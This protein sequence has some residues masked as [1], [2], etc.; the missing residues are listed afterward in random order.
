MMSEPNIIRQLPVEIVEFIFTFLDLDLSS[1][2]LLNCGTVCKLWYILS[3]EALRPIFRVLKLQDCHQ[4]R[5]LCFHQSEG[6]YVRYRDRDITHEF[7]TF[8]DIL[9]DIEII[10]DIF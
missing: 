4:S 6:G 3:R 2:D 8:G 10:P 9:E 1:S 7:D 5:L